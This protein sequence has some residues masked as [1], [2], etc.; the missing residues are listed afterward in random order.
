MSLEDIEELLEPGIDS[1]TVIQ[2][3]PELDYIQN[4]KDIPEELKKN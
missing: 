1:P 4:H 3:G 2:K